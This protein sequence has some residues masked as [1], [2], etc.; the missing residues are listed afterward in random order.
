MS[1]QCVLALLGLA[2]TGML[3]CGGG[4]EAHAFHAAQQEAWRGDGRN[5]RELLRTT[6]GPDWETVEAELSR[7]AQEHGLDLDTPLTQSWIQPWESVEERLFDG[8]VGSGFDLEDWIAQF[9]GRATLSG[10]RE[11]W[12]SELPL[13]GASLDLLP[14]GAEL[15]PLAQELQAFE[16][17][18]RST[19]TEAA[20]Q[21]RAAIEQT[22]RMG[23][24]VRSPIGI[25]EGF[26]RF[27]AGSAASIPQLSEPRGAYQYGS[28]VSIGGWIVDFVVSE[29]DHPA[30]ARALGELHAAKHDW[31]LAHRLLGGR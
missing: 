30:L 7:R 17:R 12:N 6:W 19:A 31:H 28:T 29:G 4:E 26:A 27:R 10:T 23:N 13:E 5:V 8:L 3:G 2:V 11:D 22:L 25:P 24:Y 9:S 21:V 20:L 18:V 14:A 1:R 15:S 16:E